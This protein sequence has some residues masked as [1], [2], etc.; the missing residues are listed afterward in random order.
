[1]TPILIV[2]LGQEYY[3]EMHDKLFNGGTQKI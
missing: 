1:M 2:L 3:Y